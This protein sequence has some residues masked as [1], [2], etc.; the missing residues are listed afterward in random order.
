MVPTGCTGT[1]TGVKCGKDLFYRVGNVDDLYDKGD[2]G[3]CMHK[4][5][6]NPGDPDG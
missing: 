1:M 4:R 3:I 5:D 2:D 6:P